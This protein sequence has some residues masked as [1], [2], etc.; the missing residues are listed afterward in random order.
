MIDS[1]NSSKDYFLIFKNSVITSIFVVLIRM[2]RNHFITHDG[3]PFLVQKNQSRR[4]CN[5]VIYVMCWQTVGG[6]EDVLLFN[7]LI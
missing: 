2:A 1:N 4:K 6:R 7:I 5:L 3:F